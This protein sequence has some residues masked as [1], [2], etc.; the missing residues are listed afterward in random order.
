MWGHVGCRGLGME[1]M[2]RVL[3]RSSARRAISIWTWF[4]KYEILTLNIFS[5]AALES[6]IVVGDQ[7]K[8]LILSAAVYT[9]TRIHTH[10]QTHEPH[11]HAHRHTQI[12][13]CVRNMPEQTFKCWYVIL[14]VNMY[15]HT[16]THA[17]ARAHT[18]TH[19]H[20]HQNTHTHKTH[21]HTH[22][23]GAC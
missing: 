4:V 14:G 5:G 3:E 22:T 2:K 12:Q 21:A 9:R 17:R 11:A 7:N 16:R 23:K 1:D 18:H 8:N 6:P 13:L 10:T 20:T 19:T 15:T